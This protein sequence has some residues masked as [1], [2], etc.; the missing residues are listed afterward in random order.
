MLG[1]LQVASTAPLPTCLSV[2][3]FEASLACMTLSWHL[4]MANFRFEAA[5]KLHSKCNF[6]C[7]FSS[8]AK[9]NK[10]KGT[11]KGVSLDS[12]GIWHERMWVCKC[13][14]LCVW[15][16]MARQY[17]ILNCFQSWVLSLNWIG[18]RYLVYFSDFSTQRKLKCAHVCVC[19]SGVCVCVSGV[20]VSKVC[21]C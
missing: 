12:S 15:V 5:F 10:A 2:Q 20:C 17:H 3:P 8:F 13:V 1:K 19:V 18:T 6:I 11:G 4:L 7:R 21:V 9:D 14:C 16:C